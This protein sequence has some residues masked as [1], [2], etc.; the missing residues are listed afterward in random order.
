MHVQCPRILGVG[1]EQ[2]VILDD[3]EHHL[4]ASHP[5]TTLNIPHW[6]EKDDSN[7]IQLDF[8]FQESYTFTTQS[9]P[10]LKSLKLALVKAVQEA[11]S[12]AA[13]EAH[14]RQ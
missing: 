1:T 12:S 5:I 9:K 10:V 11:R 7:L 6:T 13:E 2:V 4:I 8:K 14:Q 3:T